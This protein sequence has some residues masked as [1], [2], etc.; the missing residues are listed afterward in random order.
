MLALATVSST[1]ALR[2]IAL[3][4]AGNSSTWRGP[5]APGAYTRRSSSGAWIESSCIFVAPALAGLLLAVSSPG[6][7]F[8]VMAMAVALGAML[9]WRVPGPAPAGTTVVVDPTR[10][11]QTMTG[12]GASM[13]D[14]SAYVLSRLPAATRDQTMADLFSPATGIGISM[15]RNPMGASDFA[16]NGSYSY[17]DQPAGATD[18]TLAAPGTIRGDLGRDWGLPV[19]QNLVH[20]SDAVESAEREIA[21][22]FP[23]L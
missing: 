12:F 14:S 18:P 22:W 2:R 10:R 4:S 16:V 3:H 11:Y 21:I 9:V 8:V 13:T 5:G 7:V 17:D 6:A 19:Q 20:G 1:A 23:E 15:L